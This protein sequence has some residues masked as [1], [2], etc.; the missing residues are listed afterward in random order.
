MKKMQQPL[1][2]KENGMKLEKRGSSILAISKDQKRYFPLEIVN[3]L[4]LDGSIYL[5]QQLFNELSL[6]KILIHYY[7]YGGKYKGSFIPAEKNTGKVRQFQYE[8]YFDEEKK[9]QLAKCIVL[10]ASKNKTTLLKRYYN[11]YG[12]EDIKNRISQIEDLIKKIKGCET[13]SS[14][15]GYEGMIT[16]YY[17]SC[18]SL[19]FKNYSFGGRNRNPPTDEINCLLSWG[20]TLLYDEIRNMA[21]EVGLDLFCGFL[22]EMNDSKPTLAL[23]LAESF[24]QPIIDSLVFEIA[25]NNML[26]DYHFN[27][28]EKFCFL[29]NI[30]KQLFLKKY[31]FKMNKTFLNRKLKEYVSYRHSIKLDMYKMI[32][33]FFGESYK[34]EGM[35]IF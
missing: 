27:K 3:S 19:I 26:N 18:F 31:E 23:D 30:G 21:Y 5:S 6:R 35:R 15:R 20:N 7:S 22:H 2:F 24:R 14:V 34:F 32:K 13:I 17:F 4:R 16:K 28:K 9:L 25:N 12:K 1:Y 33:Y 8:T 29:S 11:K 10:T